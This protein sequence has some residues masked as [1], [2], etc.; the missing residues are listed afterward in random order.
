MKRILTVSFLACSLLLTACNHKSIGVIGGADGPTSIYVSGNGVKGQ[1][2]EQLEKRPVRMFNVDGDLYYDSGLVSEN[3]PRCGTMDGELK[4]TV[5][6]NEI[7]LKTGEANFEIDA[8]QHATS[9]T[10]EVNVDGEWLIFKKYD[11]YGRTLED[12]KYCYYIKGHLNHAA[13]DSEI[14]VLT[15]DE[16]ITF[17]DVYEPLLSSQLAAG[18]GMGKTL[19]NAVYNDKWGICFHA[20]AITPT[21]LTLKIEQFGGNPSGELQTGAAYFLETTVKDEWKAVGTKSGEPLVWNCLAYG[22]KKN[23]ITEMEIDWQYTY[24]ELKPGYYRLKKEIMDFREAGDFDEETYEVY[25]TI[26]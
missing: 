3:T 14:I 22:I 6:E 25:F 2:G 26:E 11:T 15:A 4:K 19:H 7:P 18:A 16:D 13:A 24:G 12:L 1:F 9:I 20:D 21:G 5:E 17:N 10:K 23:D 8:Y